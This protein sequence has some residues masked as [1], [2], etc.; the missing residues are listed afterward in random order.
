[1]QD[2]SSIGF[3]LSPQQMRLASYLAPGRAGEPYV[4][5]ITIEVEGRLDQNRLRQALEAVIRR[6]EILRTKFVARPGLKVPLQ[7]IL[8]EQAVSPNLFTLSFICH[9]GSDD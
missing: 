3:A 6:H 4:A 5:Q 8:P 9:N 7:A 1:M 2:T